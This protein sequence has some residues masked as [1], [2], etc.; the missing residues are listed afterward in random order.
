MKKLITTLI[1]LLLLTGAVNAQYKEN[2]RGLGDK[3][4]ANKDYY[5]AA[6]YYRKAAEG[7][8]LVTTQAIP[9]QS[10]AKSNKKGKPEDRA[11]VAFQLGESYRLYENYV[12]AEPWYFKVLN[13]NY[14]AQY[15]L[16]RLW[17]GV[18]LRANQHFDEAITQLKQFNTA[19]RGE[20]KYKAIA[21]KEIANCYFA[22]EQYQYPLLIDVTKMKGAWYSDGSDYALIKRNA[23]SYFTSSRFLRNEK[24]HLNRV[25]TLAGDKEA[26]PV[27]IKFKSDEKDKEVEYGTPAL[28]P[29]GQRMYFTRWYKTGS[30]T[31]HGIYYSD[32]SNNEWQEPV[33]LNANVNAEGFNSIQPFIT[34]DGKRMYFVSNKPG[35]QGADDIWYADLDGNGMP[36]NSINMGST[37]NTALDEQAPYYNITDKQLIYS[38]KGLLGLGGF[39]FYETSFDGAKWSIPAN[40][41]YPMNS[42]KDDLYYL[43]DP[44]NANKFY[45]SSDRESDC[46]LNMFEAFDRRHILSGLVT[47]CDTHKALGGVK[48]SFVD[49][50]SKQTIKTMVLGAN[51]RYNFDVKTRR[52]Y[53]LVL[54]KAGY[55]TKVVPVSASGEMRSDTL[56]NPE[57]CLQAFK[58]DKPI[59]IKNVLYDFNKAMLRPESKTVLNGVVTILKDNPKIKIEL[60]AHTD[61]VGSDKY[62]NKLSQARAQ[63][64][65]DYIIA[66]GINESRIYAKGY[67]KRRPIAP[68]SLP[69]GKD[70]PEGRQLNRRTEFT[71]LKLE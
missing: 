70:N 54:E 66:S 7:L 60:A 29:N 57:I 51:A 58:V 56:L 63:A 41:G 62:N 6:F 2:P 12:E 42:A 30:K 15:P 64:C 31:I 43:P 44:T 24:V 21:A 27:A 68:N 5:E 67:G 61:S 32:L 36:V 33:K 45:I 22:K 23:N 35:G 71:V 34:A 11:Y 16:T 38:S 13:E 65:V 10:S 52:P 40:M 4:F 18:C 47:D 20:A 69:N 25:Y 26:E 39:D 3:A 8:S 49:S 28:S 48:V 14:E 53:N 59:V 19:Y 1:A 46:C 9:Y 50:L 37:I 55:F 17:Y